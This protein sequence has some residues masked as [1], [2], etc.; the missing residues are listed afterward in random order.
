MLVLF[1]RRIDDSRA[2]VRRRPD[3]IKSNPAEFFHT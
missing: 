3:L 1:G 2:N